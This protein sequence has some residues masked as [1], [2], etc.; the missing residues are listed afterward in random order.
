MQF[1]REKDLF[2]PTKTI[3]KK[4]NQE[5]LEHFKPRALQIK[6][7]LEISDGLLAEAVKDKVQEIHGDF[8]R[9]AITTGLRTI[10]ANAETHLAMIQCRHGPHRLVGSSLPFLTK[11]KDENVVPR[12]IYTGA[13]IKKC[14]ERIEKYQKLQLEVALKE[15]KNSKHTN[16]KEIKEFEEKMQTI[17]TMK[18]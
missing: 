15:L 16:P 18:H 9:A 6:K 12:L 10:Y 2:D 17:R 13:T 14:Y 11:L 7:P 1:D 4:K 3:K 5:I 8:G